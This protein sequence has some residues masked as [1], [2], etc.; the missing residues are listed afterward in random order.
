[1]EVLMMSHAL[2]SARRLNRHKLLLSCATLAIAAAAMAPQ[3]ARAQAFQGT[4]TTAA[5]TVG[6][7]RSTPGSETITVGSSTATINW[8]PSDTQG[9][10]NINFLPLGNAATY[11]GS[12]G[13]ADF[14]VL[15]RIV[16]TDVTRTIE[17]NGT[18]LGKLDGGATGGNVWFY[19]PGGILIGSQA[20]F[21]VGGLLLSTLDVPGG[22]STGTGSFTATFSKTEATAGSIKVLSGAQINAR[23][24]YVAMIAPRIEQGGN[25]QV[26]GSA[27]YAAADEATM[28]L[29]QGLFDIE[30]PFDK[31]TSDSNGIVHTGS[32]GGPANVGATDNHTI[33]MVAVP[34]NQALTM[35]LGG[36]VGFAPAATGAAVEN[37]QIVL[38][39][40]FGWNGVGA[41]GS[42]QGA[43]GINIGSSGA[44]NFTSSIYGIADGPIVVGATSGNVAFSGNIT[45]TDSPSAGGGDIELLADN[46][47]KLSI[48]GDALLISS[49]KVGLSADHAGSINVTGTL[50]AS[51][52]NLFSMFDDNGLGTIQADTLFF[53]TSNVASQAQPDITNLI[54][55]FTG[56]YTVTD[57]TIPGDLQLI[58]GGNLTAGNL[59][60]GTSLSLY[61][62]GDLS[63]QD[64]TVTGAGGSAT[65]IAGGTANFHGIV[66]AGNIFVDSADIDIFSGA[67]LGVLG[68][69][70]LVGLVSVNDN[71]MYIGAGLTPPAGAYTLN[72]AG[73]IHGHTITVT[74]LSATDTP[75]P[76]IIIGDVKVDGSQTVGGGITNV[77][78]G[79]SNGSIK[80]EGAI[81]F[82]NT[83]ASDSLTLNAG[84]AVEVNT[85]TGSLAMTDPAGNL[86]AGLVLDAPNLWIASQSILSQ[87]EADPNFAGRDSQLGANSGTSNPLGF[88]GVGGISALFTGT[89]FVQNSG[90]ATDMGG[91]S[92][93]DR[94]LFV[95]N[96]GTSAAAAVTATVTASISASAA[97]ASTAGSNSGA[98]EYSWPDSA[99]WQPKRGRYWR[100]EPARAATA[101]AGRSSATSRG[102]ATDRR[103]NAGRGPGAGWRPDR[104]W[105]PDSGTS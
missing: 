65:F 50:E 66:N 91:L 9:T 59:T 71:P 37:G 24:S 75:T 20:V 102:Q 43:G 89:F 28:T 23:S 30:V 18:V 7:A 6:Y 17:L 25:V 83:G 70:Q 76:D 4:P 94:G 12:S 33:Y 93:G 56:D 68:V 58:G 14:T 47:S 46:E 5:G 60:A 73:D 84:N 67:S 82:I 22:V 69:T 45:L 15:N 3:R 2:C 29:N 97:A 64:A 19:S 86:G 42:S 40:G 8:A 103:S 74:A 105:G 95:E 39:S 78:V 38:S 99:G 44:S 54:G 26:N 11:Q 41:S 61:A 31:G 101:A 88:V 1:M 51:A 96:F 57:L 16:P 36:S 53:V 48:T 90:T 52:D 77:I 72:E 49:D 10:G 92:V 80:V 21:D 100:P 79:T 104:G 63:V 98:G 62:N 81:R 32:T 27:A 85:D 35:L 87:L 13:L 55:E 34:K